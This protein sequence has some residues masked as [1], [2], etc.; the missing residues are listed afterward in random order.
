M[1]QIQKQLIG[2]VE[3]TVL[4]GVDGGEMKEMTTTTDMS[5]TFSGAE[6]GQNIYVHRRCQT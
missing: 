2:D 4:A 1:H 3:F 5:V 6:P